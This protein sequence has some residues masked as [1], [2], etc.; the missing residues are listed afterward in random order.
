MPDQP[1]PTVHRSSNPPLAVSAISVDEVSLP[2][3][4]SAQANPSVS[5]LPHVHIAPAKRGV[6]RSARPATASAVERD[7]FLLPSKPSGSSVSEGSTPV[8]SPRSQ[9]P[10]SSRML[11]PKDA[12]SAP[13]DISHKN[14]MSKPLYH[15]V[16][17]LRDEMSRRSDPGAPSSLSEAAPATFP[18]HDHTS[19]ASYLQRKGE[20]SVSDYDWAAFISAYA[21]GRWDPHKTPNPPRSSFYQS[22]GVTDLTSAIGELDLEEPTPVRD[23][24][25]FSTVA[26]S[27]KVSSHEDECDTLQPSGLPGKGSSPPDILSPMASSS[28]S[29]PLAR[30]PV[31]NPPPP[32]TSHRL[33]NSFADIRSS[34]HPRPLPVSLDGVPPVS[35][36]ESATAAAAMR[37]AA[38]RVNIAPLALPSPEHELTDPFRNAMAVLPGT[39]GLGDISAGTASLSPGRKPRLASFWEGTTDVE[40][41]RLSSIQGSPP[42]TPP[43]VD[44]PAE[45]PPDESSPFSLYVK[46]GLPQPATVPAGSN[47][48]HD[49]DDDYFGIGSSPAHSP[50]SASLLRPD[51]PRHHTA[52]AYEGSSPAIQTVP[53]LP[54]RVILTRQTSSPLPQSVSPESLSG[55][56]TGSSS[57]ITLKAG[58]S[59]KEESMFAELGYLAP[60]YPPDELERR[61]ALHQFNIWATGPDTNFDRIEHL[62]KLV[63]NSK[64]VIISLIDGNEQW[65]KSASGWARDVHTV[66]RTGCICAHAILQRGDEPLVVLDTLEDWRFEKNPL[67]VGPS[68]VR[69]YAG[70]PLRT[71]DGYNIGTLAVMDD[72][73]RQDFSPRQRHTLKEF[74]A[75]AMREME[76]WRDKIQLRIRDRIQ[77]S[78]EQF[79]RECLEIDLEPSEGS[80]PRLTSSF[81]M[82][83]VYG[84]AAKLVKK[85]LD[86]EGAIVMDVS[87]GEVLETVGSE[88]IVSVLVHSADASV[89]TTTHQLT[90][91]DCGK[92][93]DTFMKYPDGRIFEGVVPAPLRPFIPSGIQYA[94]SVPIFNIDK[95]PFAVICA[96]NSSEH[97]KRFLEGHELSYLR[98]IGVIILSA[99]LKRRMTLADKA[100]SLFISNISHELRTPLHGILAAAELLADTTL[101]HSQVSFLQTVQACGTSL[102]E[103]VN[104]VLDFTKLSGNAKAGGLEHVIHLTKVDLM[105]LVEEAVDGCWIGHRARTHAFNDSE[106]GSLYSPPWQDP[107][108][109]KVKKHVEIV[110]EIGDREAGWALKCE[111]GGI[112]RVLMNLFGNSLKFTS[113]GYIHVLLRQ[114]PSSPDL[115]PD[116]VKIELSVVDTG[117]GISQDF[118][119]NQLF[120]PFSQENPLQTGTGLGLAI[121]NSIVQ[122]KAVDGKVDVWS[123]ENVGTEIKVTIMAERTADDSANTIFEPLTT[124]YSRTI[125]LHGFDG[126]HRGVQ[127]LRRVVTNYLVKWWGF[128]LA[129]PGNP[130]D[131]VVTNDDL[132]P[133]SHAIQRKDVGRPFIILTEARGD[134]QLGAAVTEFERL[135]GFCRTVFKPGGPSRLRAAL[136]LCLHALKIAETTPRVSGSTTPVAGQ[137]TL[138]SPSAVARRNSEET[139]GSV[140][141]TRRPSLGPRS[142]TVHPTATWNDM[143]ATVQ[144]E[145]PA[146]EEPPVGRARA[147]SQSHMAPSPTIPVGTGGSLLKSSVGSLGHANANAMRV[148]VVEDNS[149]LRNLLIKWLSG[150]GYAFR[151]AVDG[152]EGVQVFE[153]DGLF[154][155]V[156]LD[157]S[158]PV[159]DGYGA[160]TQIRRIEEFRQSDHRC[161]ILALTGMSS[162]EDKRRAFEAGVDG[163]LVKPVAFK[164]LSEIFSRLGMS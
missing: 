93:W 111:K 95:Q 71:Q 66:P 85:T 28:R 16:M 2:L 54:R 148:L 27:S 121:V 57:A 75:I 36:T 29:S 24:S 25:L 15:S 110:V 65:M 53:A 47:A 70:A 117:K 43:N 78:M 91:E 122:S 136:K 127:L 31:N 113:D 120:H 161:R 149:I 12:D 129:S 132:A 118:L 104:H 33:R 125:L 1:P 106:I 141:G 137:P 46:P 45:K 100:K 76:L 105:Q 80:E 60:P 55:Q 159:L 101:T 84:R 20:P 109:N 11:L 49:E 99:V 68:L 97:G 130:G 6:R 69:F 64:T 158:M 160:T 3:S 114:L 23:A 38:V 139:S 145:G 123:A 131:I 61:R 144:E 98:A 143:P 40:P 18:L 39:Y 4:L 73:P 103:T 22:L 17:S 21:L 150:K 35:I 146:S 51:A 37:W 153:S 90:A 62:T 67:V 157:L 107:N 52:P 154:D 115:K 138:I 112:R 147:L 128:K 151:D 88:A 82:D 7:S 30:R 152:R 162:L 56:R 126:A 116:E 44:V 19:E 79:T 124:E 108:S 50:P 77:T 133:L 96:Y 63:F 156:L 163:Y 134:A 142:I 86:V 9:S 14:S 135:G 89:G 92:L 58:R 83:Q 42:S 32:S 102:V 48:E 140:V 26:S 164:T 155:V 72:V 81:S 94:L 10:S 8:A 5:F 119:K 41:G 34:T 74:A 13:G 87:H 59:M